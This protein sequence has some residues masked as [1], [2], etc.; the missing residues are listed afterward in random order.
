MT[1]ECI[2]IQSLSLMIRNERQFVL[3]VF[4]TACHNDVLCLKF[5]D[6]KLSAFILFFFHSERLRYA[7]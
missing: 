4:Y 6:I 1:I 7:K 2:Q 3:L 5:D